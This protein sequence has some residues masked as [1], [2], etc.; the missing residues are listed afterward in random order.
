PAEHSGQ[1]P[2]PATSTLC[3]AT[4]ISWMSVAVTTQGTIIRGELATRLAGAV[5]VLL[6]IAA[7]I[8]PDRL[9]A[10]VAAPLAGGDAIA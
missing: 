9:P 8:M 3:I 10:I 4:G 7:I 1:H 6:G 5:M 2:Q